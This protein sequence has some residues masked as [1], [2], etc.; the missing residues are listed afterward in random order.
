[1]H[2]LLQAALVKM[3]TN[4]ISCSRLF[5]ALWKDCDPVLHS[6]GVSNDELVLREIN[7]FYAKSEAFRRPQPRPVEQ[8]DHQLM[9]T[10]SL[11]SKII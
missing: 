2:G 3:K 8:F 10:R 5:D 11:L 4:G 1:M 9:S 6:F 7:I